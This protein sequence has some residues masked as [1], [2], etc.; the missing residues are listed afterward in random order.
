MLIVFA[1]VLSI[2]LL[3]F[4]GYFACKIK[5]LP[6]ES[7]KYL[8]NLML[9]I[10]APCMAGASIYQK[11]LTDTVLSATKQVLIGAAIF[12]IICLIIALL[13]VKVFKF[14][15]KDWGIYITAVTCINTGFMGF[16]VTKAIFGEDIFYLMV[17]HNIIACIF[18]YGIAPILLDTSSDSSPKGSKLSS[19]K[20]MVN[21]CTVGIVIGV[22]MLLLGIKPPE[23]IDSVIMSLADAT[24]PISMIIVG[25]QLAGSNLKE[26]LKDKQI[27][28]INVVSM[29]IIPILTFLVVDQ[30]DMINPKVKLL[31]IFASVFPTAVAPAAI[32]EQRGVP[33]NKLAEIVSV[34]TATSMIVIPLMA[35]ILMSKYM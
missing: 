6:A 9:Y 5:I 7:K 16:P 19:L 33:S 22:V 28:I 12:F 13:V 4:L 24:V 14:P 35:I 15:K 8:I 31:L 17:M 10:T 1:R 18:I 34:T 29:I 27:C 20:L 26:I 11:E 3:T 23:T 30:F 25:I 2:F 21:P 32:A